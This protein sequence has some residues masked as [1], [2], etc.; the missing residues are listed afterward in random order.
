MAE[1]TV[2][3]G[4]IGRMSFAEAVSAAEELHGTL[5]SSGSYAPPLDIAASFRGSGVGPSPAYSYSAAVVD[6]DADAR[7]GEVRVNKVWIAHDIGRTLN[8]LL[9]KGQVEGSVYMA[10]GEALLEEQA[11]RKGL[12]RQPS[13]LDYK[14]LTCLDMPEIETLLV[15]TL[16]PEGPY[17]AK[18]VGQGP[19]LP[20]IPAVVAAIHD[21]LGIW[22]DEV[23]ATPDKVLR[24]LDALAK[25]APARV[26]PRRF[27][28]I[29][30]PPCTKVA[31][32]DAA[33]ASL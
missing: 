26:G 2:G 16:D 10:L 17:G 19:L 27:P 18:E 14:S 6:L 31:L 32:P 20:V 21:A 22:V 13:V 1:V 15:E 28:E 7:T 33:T 9:V 12:H 30:Y 8:P 11:Y 29:P 5:V 24:A 4:T 23:P 3:A 25:G